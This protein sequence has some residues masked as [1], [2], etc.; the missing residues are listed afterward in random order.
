MYM[1]YRYFQLLNYVAVFLGYLPEKL[2][3]PLA[4]IF[5][6]EQFFTIFRTPYQMI[7]AVIN[8]MACSSN[9]HAIYLNTQSPRRIRETSSPPYN[10]LGNDKIHPR[11]KTR[12]ILL[13]SRQEKAFKFCP[14]F[15][16]LIQSIPFLIRV[17]ITPC[18]NSVPLS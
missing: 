15:N 3:C 16:L 17:F 18:T 2:F 14:F 13:C 11:V 7:S 9:T 10:P 6:P 5:L 8:R 1:I 4:Q 12:G